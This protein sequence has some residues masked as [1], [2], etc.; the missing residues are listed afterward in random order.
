MQV[1]IES[2]GLTSKPPAAVGKAVGPVLLLTRGTAAGSAWAVFELSLCMWE[3]AVR[4][5]SSHLEVA[6]SFHVDDV[7]LD[8]EDEC[9]VTLVKNLLRR[10][11]AS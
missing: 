9:P 10:Q 5:K 2:L 7:P 8:A 1:H 6:I 3:G 11:K 4:F